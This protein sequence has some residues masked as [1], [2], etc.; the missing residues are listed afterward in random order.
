MPTVLALKKTGFFLVMGYGHIKIFFS[1]CIRDPSRGICPIQM[2]LSLTSNICFDDLLLCN[3]VIQILNTYG[4]FR[5][6]FFKLP[7]RLQDRFNALLKY[8]RSAA[9]MEGLA[10]E[11]T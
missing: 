3:L 4:T 8:F 11:P 1:V 10:A 9:N 7:P 5:L 6:L 2:L